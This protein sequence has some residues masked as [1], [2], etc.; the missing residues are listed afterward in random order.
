MD[1]RPL[2]TRQQQQ[3]HPDRERFQVER[4]SITA[5]SLTSVQPD[6]ANTAGCQ[7]HANVIGNGAVIMLWVWLD[8]PKKNAL[9]RRSASEAATPLLSSAVAAT[10]GARPV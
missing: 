9:N 4:T 5:F 10:F 1:V 7:Q 6:H 2:G 3:H 8:C